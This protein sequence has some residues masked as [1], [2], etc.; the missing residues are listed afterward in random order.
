MRRS[1]MQLAVWLLLAAVFLANRSFGQ[2]AQRGGV[3]GFVLDAS[4]AAV[5]NAEVTLTDLGQSHTRQATTDG[6]G[7]FVF[8][9]LTA[10]QYRLSVKQQGFETVMSEPITLNIGRN[11]R[12]D[13]RLRPG[14]ATQ[15][16]TVTS[17]TVAL[18]TGQANLSTNVSQQQIEQLPLNGRNFTAIAGLAPGVATTPQ[19]NINPGGTF[20]VGAQFASGG[21]FFTTGG[22]IEGSRDNGF[23][24]NGV[25]IN[26][27]Y[28]SSLSY[29]P[30]IEAL[31]EGSIQIADFSASNGHDISTLTMQTRA[32]TNRFHGHAYEYLE[33]DAMN[34]V[35]SF[36]KAESEIVLGTPATKPT[37]RRNQF[38]GGVGGPVYIPKILT[39]LKDKAFFFANYENFIESDGS[40]PVFASVPSA[41]ERTGDFSELLSGP[42]PLQ[43]YNPFDTTYDA[44]GFS[45]Q[46]DRY[47]QS[48]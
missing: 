23:Y 9:D 8:S 37:L 43:L 11:S 1:S 30:S 33:N 45:F 26:D 44:N 3:E 29:E 36:D 12:Y 31:A 18:E 32:G 15:S 4:G 22:L 25:N 13:F 27:N 34:A 7:H 39:L 40:E 41:A 10:G 46:T 5:V 21:T 24:V 6:T 14:S 48:S 2:F 28:E 35:N 17:N 47:E 20:S 16:V 38:G 42:N 19:L